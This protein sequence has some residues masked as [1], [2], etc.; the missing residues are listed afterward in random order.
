MIFDQDNLSSR[1]CELCDEKGTILY[2][3]LSD[4]AFKYRTLIHDPKGR[5]LAYVQ[6][7]ISQEDVVVFCDPDDHYLGRLTG[8]K[9]ALVTFG[10]EEPLSVSSLV[11]ISSGAMEVYEEKDLF[12]AV[13]ILCAGIEM[14]RE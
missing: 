12:K 7:D 9:D 8:K 11:K 14:V 4:F 5:L 10:D 13:L 6:K 3:S 2:R 1:H